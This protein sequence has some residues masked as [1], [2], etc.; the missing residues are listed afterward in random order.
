M[1]DQHKKEKE[2]DEVSGV[3]TTGHEWDGLKELNN[4]LPRWWLW[5]LY[6]SII[7]SFWYFVVYP[8][9]PVPGG[10]TEGTSGYTQFRELKESQD[11][12]VARQQKYLDRFEHASFD[13]IMNDAELYAFAVAG[14]SSAFKDNCATCHGTG[15]EGGK[16]YPNLNDD[17][18]LWGGTMSEI[19]E[20]LQYGI[21]ADNLDTRISQMPA[22]GQDELLKHDEIDAVVDYVMTLSG[23]KRGKN[24]EKGYEVYK[25]QCASCHADD[26]KGD[27]MFGAPNLA[28]K[29]WL[30]GGGR[31]AVYETVFYARA[32]MM[33]AWENRLDENTLKQLTVY[34]HQLGGGED[35]VVDDAE[36][37]DITP[38][39]EERVIEDNI[40]DEQSEDDQ[41]EQQSVIDEFTE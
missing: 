19:F 2:I 18:W 16:G 30:Y 3:E 23:S 17:D 28:D 40:T 24:H 31:D 29:I 25:A 5:V 39:V 7:W 20:T 9:W 27:H 14:G 34:L 13:K 37:P 26:G 33:P 38:Q 41:Q 6:V 22:F 32:G 11:E 21:R 15:A 1:S 36:E 8:S 35:D 4:P 10:A 12:I